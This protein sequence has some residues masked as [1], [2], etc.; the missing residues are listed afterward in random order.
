MRYRLLGPLEVT[1]DTGEAVALAGER[2]RTLLAALLLSAGRT[3]SSS[4]LIDLLWGEDPPATASNALQVQ[5]SKLRKKLGTGAIESAGGGYVLHVADDD[6]D[7]VR[8]EDLAATDFGDPAQVAEALREALALWRGTALADVAAESLAGER[9]RLEELRH[10]VLERRIEADLAL[11]RHAELIGELEALVHEDPLREATRGQLMVALYRG[12]RQADALALYR[13]GREV[14]GEELGIDPGPELQAL[15]VAIL[16]Q[17]PDLAAPEVHPALRSAQ[18]A[19]APP[20]GTLT[21]LMTDIEGST[22]LWEQHPDEMARALRRHDE[23]LRTVI[24][25]DGGYVFKTVGDAFWAAFET[26]G[27]ASSAAC[28]AQRVLDAETWPEPITLRVRMALHTGSC[29]ERDGDFFGP[30]VNRTARLEATAH[31]GQVVV[32]RATAELLADELP[33]GTSLRDLGEHRLKDLGRPER[34]FQLDIAGI[35]TEFPPLRSLD[36]R[37]LSNNL[38]AQFSSFIGRSTEQ[39]ELAE[40]IDQSR[41]VTVTGP[42]GAGKTRLALQV[43]ADLLDGSGDGVWFVDLAPLSDP[44][45][46]ASSV[47]SALGV[48]EEPSRPVVETL[49][50]SLGQR[51]LLIV[52]DNCEHVLDASLKTADALLRQ[53]PNLHLVATSREPMGLEAERTYRIPPLSMSG[54]DDDGTSDAETLFV[55]RA[56]GTLQ[57]F[58]LDDGTRPVVAEI[59]R[60]LDGMPLAIEL[61]ATRLRTMSLNDLARR[62]DQRFGLLTG[63]SRGAMPRQ[64][65]LR[66]LIDWSYELLDQRERSVLCRLSV[67]AGGWDLDA[68]EALCATNG[69]EPWEVTDVLG[70]LADKSLVSLERDKGDVRYGMLETIRQYAAD[71]LV[72]KGDTERPLARTIHSEYFL[73]LAEQ[74]CDGLVGADQL[75]WFDRLEVEH[76]N[77]RSTIEWLLADPSSGDRA[78]RLLTALRSFWTVRHIREGIDLATALLHHPSTSQSDRHRASVLA[79]LGSL[80]EVQDRVGYLEEGLDLARRLDDDALTAQLLADLSWSAL[81]DS[82]CNLMDQRISEALFHARKAGAADLIA[83][84]LTISGSSAVF[85]GNNALGRERL[86]EAYSVCQAS[87]NRIDG[88]RALINL[89]NLDMT[90]RNYE[91]ARDHFAGGASVAEEMGFS[92][93]L[94]ISFLM[95]G[96]ANLLV[97]ELVAAR[98]WLSKGAEVTCGLDSNPFSVAYSYLYI[99]LFATATAQYEASATLQGGSDAF[100]DRLGS[101]REPLEAEWHDENERKLRRA[102]SNGFERAYQAGQRLESSE[103]NELCLEVLRPGL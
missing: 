26:A 37:Q 68:A 3:V 63:G 25:S 92:H 81:R 34:V 18:P 35:D 69:L 90:E 78:P 67:F 54:G 57:D 32:S 84:C 46:V 98:T 48:H 6:V 10:W 59:C 103:L 96:V 21:L 91:A 5:V 53:C 42:G 13:A 41:L 52:L 28:E 11:G 101:C 85:L 71:R 17:D 77:I 40:L 97:D 14:L 56:R 83:N 94:G 38:P 62:L 82:D 47:A 8:F 27:A 102:L 86:E 66:A 30:A 73:S 36:N 12:G 58:E 60:H 49:A 23:V 43:A 95:L 20:S 1:D 7:L 93:G 65:T 75:I 88:A 2:E 87:G 9:T 100:F 19:P 31:G 16:R 44:D 61:A 79:L 64:Q 29:D 50:R 99:A 55:E 70:S 24:E 89:G 4:R 39:A 74:A 45:L 72:E 15:E 22:R 80:L 33:D 51:R 76:D